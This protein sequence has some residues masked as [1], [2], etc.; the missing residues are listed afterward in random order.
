MVSGER[1]GS[2]RFAGIISPVKVIQLRGDRVCDDI[3]TQEK[4]LF[5]SFHRRRIGKTPYREVRVKERK[6]VLGPE[7]K[8]TKIEIVLLKEECWSF[9]GGGRQ[10]AR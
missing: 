10:V 4:A 1:G 5:G 6:V 7:G 9:G 8:R 3:V 2:A